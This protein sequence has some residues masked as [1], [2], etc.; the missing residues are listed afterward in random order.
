ML[1]KVLNDIHIFNWQQMLIQLLRI[2][3]I[4]LK[5]EFEF[6]C[7]CKNISIIMGDQQ[8]PKSIATKLVHTKKKY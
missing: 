7:G 2:K 1:F 8:V 5:N 6:H 4:S 3:L